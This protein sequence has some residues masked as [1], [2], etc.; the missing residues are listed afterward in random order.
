[1]L[2]NPPKPNEDL[3]K[4]FKDNAEIINELR[5]EVNKLKSD[6]DYDAPQTRHEMGQ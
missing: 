1:M 4:L 5:A 6:A 3:K 2:E